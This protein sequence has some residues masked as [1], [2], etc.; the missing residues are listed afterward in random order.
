MFLGPVYLW[1]EVQVGYYHPETHEQR[2]HT[3]G[4]GGAT[5]RPRRPPGGEGRLAPPGHLCR[6]VGGQVDRWAG[7][8]V[9]RGTG[10]QVGR[11]T[12]RVQKKLN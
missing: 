12:Y 4:A 1:R 2:A 6:W 3:P 10:G 11:G 9:D 5:G 8:Q 7:G